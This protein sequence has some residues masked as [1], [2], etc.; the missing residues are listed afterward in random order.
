M[1]KKISP[2]FLILAIG[3]LVFAGCSKKEKTMDISAFTDRVQS[4]VTYDDELIALSDKTVGNYYDLSFDGLEEWKILASPLPHLLLL[5]EIN[6][7]LM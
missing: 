7:S 4:E 1:K 3:I 6:R 2:L 5:Q